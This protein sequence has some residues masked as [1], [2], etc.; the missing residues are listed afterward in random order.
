MNEHYVP[1]VHVPY[2]CVLCK[3]SYFRVQ[4]CVSDHLKIAQFLGLFTDT[5]LTS[6]IMVYENGA[7][8]PTCFDDFISLLCCP[9][10]YASKGKETD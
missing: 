7:E 5:S 4:E 9:F 3:Y 6:A 1:D 2:F 8:L 10:N